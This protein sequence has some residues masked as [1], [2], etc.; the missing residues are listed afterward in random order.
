MDADSG[1]KPRSVSSSHEKRWNGH[2]PGL[3][4]ALRYIYA[5]SHLSPTQFLEALKEEVRINLARLSNKILFTA[6]ND[7]EAGCVTRT[8]AILIHLHHLPSCRQDI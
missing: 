1:T 7:K 5:R 2:P 8:I 4:S 6:W 3:L